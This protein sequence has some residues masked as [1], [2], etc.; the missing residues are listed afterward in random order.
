MLNLTK[1]GAEKDT[2]LTKLG[3]KTHFRHQ[4]YHATP[5]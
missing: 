3:A 2:S 1:L 5:V 4:N